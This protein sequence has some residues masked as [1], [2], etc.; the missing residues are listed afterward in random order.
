[1]ISPS[2]AFFADGGG[3]YGRNDCRYAL[4]SPF[5]GAPLGFAR[6]D[7]LDGEWMGR[8]RRLPRLFPAAPR[9]RPVAA[10]SCFGDFARRLFFTAEG[11]AGDISMPCFTIT[12]GRAA[13]WARPDKADFDDFC[14]A[15]ADLSGEN[16]FALSRHGR[17]KSRGRPS[18]FRDALMPGHGHFL[19]TLTSSFRPRHVSRRRGSMPPSRVDFGPHAHCLITPLRSFRR[20][21]MPRPLLMPAEAG[22]RR[23]APVRAASADMPL[24]TGAYETGRGRRPRVSE[25]C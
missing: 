2:L 24:K 19:S 17:L 23:F 16:A 15:S 6:E 13:G 18:S 11:F 7:G 1:M 14:R 21:S 9:F 10:A 3:D 22:R 12:R 8:R 25:A 20:Q 4:I 5:R